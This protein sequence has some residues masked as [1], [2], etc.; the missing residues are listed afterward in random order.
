MNTAKNQIR[1]DMDK[2]PDELQREAD[3]TR[4]DIERTVDQLAN[5]FSPGELINQGMRKL[6]S[7]GGRTFVHNLST[8]IQGNP[9]PVILAG[10]SLTWLMTASKRPPAQAPSSGSSPGAMA[11]ARDKLSSASQSTRDSAGQLAESAREKQHQLADGAGR[12]K[13]HVSDS[14]Q[15]IM[16]SAGRGARSARS[17]YDYLLREQP[18]VLGMMAIAAG[19]A[20]GALLPRTD[21]ENRAM[22][23][24]S[25]EQKASVKQRAEEAK[26][27]AETKVEEKLDQQQSRTGSSQGGSEQS[28]SAKST[29]GGPGTTSPDTR[30]NDAQSTPSSP[31]PH[32][33]GAQESKARPDAGRT[34]PSGESTPSPSPERTGG[35]TEEGAPA[36]KPSSGTNRPDTNPPL[37]NPDKGKEK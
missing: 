12:V 30:S 3:E 14:G 27:H 35:I 20:L 5:Q 17:Q 24:A 34:S 1:R 15:R 29:A 21:P 19:A 9:I 37:L 31:Q 8:Q 2:S 6:Q 10:V 7:G 33:H 16:D 32:S 25:D 36:A 23:T 13:Q 11:T 28:P 4:K 18:L 22:G 26:A